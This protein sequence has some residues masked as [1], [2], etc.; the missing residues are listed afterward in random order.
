MSRHELLLHYQP[1]ID[2]RTGAALGAEALLR[3]QHPR[4]GLLP[5][6]RFI[7]RAEECGQMQAL[8]RH[9]LR[10]ACS[11]L[12]QWKAA[13]LR[14]GHVA[15]NLSAG[16]FRHEQLPRLVEQLIADGDL[17]EINDR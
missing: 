15:V 10:S 3:W 1:V 6:A 12:A 13:G 9:T 8:G 11:Q 5:P 14:V 2:T 4:Q 16:E 17:C 7:H